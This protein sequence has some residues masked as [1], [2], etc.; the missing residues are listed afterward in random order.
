[1][2]ECRRNREITGTDRNMTHIAANGSHKMI[3]RSPNAPG[4]T[5]ITAAQQPARDGG[6]EQRVLQRKIDR[7][8]TCITDGLEVSMAVFTWV[9]SE[10][11]IYCSEMTVLR[12]RNG[13]KSL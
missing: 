12:A 1:M 4:P 11:I 7:A 13:Q 8:L 3:S 2:R 6:E 9:K 5:R 10:D